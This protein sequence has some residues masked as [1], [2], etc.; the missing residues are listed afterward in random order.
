MTAEEIKFIYPKLRKATN[1]IVFA[2]DESDEV[3]I[4]TNLTPAQALE[5]IHYIQQL[6]ENAK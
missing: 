1:H 4:A 3:A 6:L 2:F 5:V